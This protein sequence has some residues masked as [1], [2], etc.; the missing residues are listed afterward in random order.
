MH[1]EGG[2]GPT[3]SLRSAV[4]GG[5]SFAVVT[6]TVVVGFFVCFCVASLGLGFVG[7]LVDFLLTAAVPVCFLRVTDCCVCLSLFLTPACLL[8][9]NTTLVTAY[10]RKKTSP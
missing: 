7:A 4:W 6:E 10:K 3:D 5:L 2:D 1:L 8:A 9:G